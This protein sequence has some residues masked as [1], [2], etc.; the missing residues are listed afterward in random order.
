M[1]ILQKK[2][3]KEL[4]SILREYK[5][6]HCRPYSRLKKAQM[7]ELIKYH[8]ISEHDIEKTGKIKTKSKPKSKIKSVRDEH[9]TI[10]KKLTKSRTDAQNIVAKADNIMNK[11][12][13][14]PKSE[15]RSELEKE[16][17]R[18][19]ALSEPNRKPVPEMYTGEVE[20]DVFVTHWGRKPTEEEKKDKELMRLWRIME[21]RLKDVKELYVQTGYKKKFKPSMKTVKK[22]IDSF[23]EINTKIEEMTGKR[24]IIVGVNEPSEIKTKRLRA[25]RAYEKATK[26]DILKIY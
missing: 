1:D 10:I 19:R 21:D 4:K 13:P 2:T 23:N 5:K 18:L 3:V 22:T 8:G 14:K 24:N 26:P 6:I 17:K 15:S 7:I 20:K 12:A 11:K 25:E 9:E 16:Y